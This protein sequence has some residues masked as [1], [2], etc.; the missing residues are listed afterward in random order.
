MVMGCVGGR[1]E[2]R[3]DGGTSWIKIRSHGI[4]HQSAP[5]SSPTGRTFINV[6]LSEPR[7]VS[8]GVLEQRGWGP[9]SPE[10][11]LRRLGE[12][13][14]VGGSAIGCRVLVMRWGC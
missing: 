14:Y 7:K 4:W 13:M 11:V 3:G 2:G 8:G 6:T 1:E 10:F 12:R 9:A 5:S